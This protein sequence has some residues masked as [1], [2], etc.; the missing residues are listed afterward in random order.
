MITPFSDCLE[1]RVPRKA[2]THVGN[3][4]TETRNIVTNWSTNSLA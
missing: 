1:S 2:A 3:Y 4:D